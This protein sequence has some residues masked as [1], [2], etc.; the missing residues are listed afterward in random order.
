MRPRVLQDR[1]AGGSPSAG[2]A[3]QED[4]LEDRGPEDQ[5]EQDGDD[6]G[7]PGSHDGLRRWRVTGV[8]TPP[9][10]SPPGW[11]GSSSSRGTRVSSSPASRPRR[12]AADPRGTHTA[13][14][15]ELSTV[16]PTC[17]AGRAP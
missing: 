6:D 11:S 1:A 12:S 16:S 10:P 13:S 15:P 5:R 17:P 9:S 14:R 3:G 7:R 2:S 8:V 4:E